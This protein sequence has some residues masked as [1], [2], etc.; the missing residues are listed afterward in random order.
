MVVSRVALQAAVAALTAGYVLFPNS[1][2]LLTLDSNLFWDN[3]NKRLGVGTITPATALEV[4]GVITKTGD[5]P[6][7]NFLGMK[8]TS[9]ATGNIA[10][11][12]TYQCDTSLG[13]VLFAFVTSV[14]VNDVSRGLVV[15]SSEREN[16]TDHVLINIKNLGA[17]TGNG[18][19]NV[20]Y[21]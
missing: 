11:G 20:L 17:D 3:T 16:G 7:T 8:Y 6:G 5:T 2:G 15:Y 1:D 18:T 21:I 12:A 13:T 19:V 14:W 4:N 10:P 9:F